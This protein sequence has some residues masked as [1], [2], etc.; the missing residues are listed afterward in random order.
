M[1]LLRLLAATLFFSAFAVPVTAQDLIVTTQ[2]DSL[3]C[4]VTRL[5]ADFVYFTFLHENEVRKTILPKKQ[6]RSLKMNFFPVPEIPAGE[7][8][9][10]DDR[11]KLRAGLHGGW[12]RLIAPVN[13][14]VSHELQGHI[15]GF[16]S[17]YH[18]GA[19]FTFFPAESF[20]IGVK[21]S[22]FRTGHES[23]NLYVTSPKTGQ[24]GTGKIKDDITLHY[25][26]PSLCLQTSSVRQ[27]VNVIAEISMGYLS[28]TNKAVVIDPFTLSGGT[29]SGSLALG[30]DFRIREG[31]AAGF[32]ISYTS[33][34]FGQIR[35]DD[36]LYRRTIVLA[37]DN[38]ENLTRIDLSLGI[39][40]KF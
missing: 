25:I 2:G 22:L 14:N 18:L 27:K 7:I 13:T 37:K 17:G 12:S 8:R 9:K 35:Y 34:L 36:G 1:R 24:T 21:Y 10:P 33:G 20:G 26:G 4:R 23:D 6:V 19:D 32:Y 3:N 30:A 38:P 31:L 5:A 11:R 40:W 16:R 29:L 15:K 28:Y 39:R